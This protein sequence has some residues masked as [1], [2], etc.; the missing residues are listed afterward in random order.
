[1]CLCI[2][3]NTNVYRAVELS[4]CKYYEYLLM[5][6]S[7][8]PADAGSRGGSARRPRPGRGPR[9][10][11]P[12]RPSRPSP[13]L[14]AADLL[15]LHFSPHCPDPSHARAS[16]AFNPSEG[17][18]SSSSLGSPCRPAPGPAAKRSAVRGAGPQARR[19]RSTTQRA[20]CGHGPA[21]LPAGLLPEP[22]S[23][24][25]PARPPAILP[26]FSH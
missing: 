13:P 16:K 18:G 25:L 14:G 19:A 2:Y 20:L 21:L 23:G 5:A 4:G 8:L 24:L 11:R 1:M 17:S 3:Q 9:R 12:P 22:S 26:S 7:K 10:P 6:G 15:L